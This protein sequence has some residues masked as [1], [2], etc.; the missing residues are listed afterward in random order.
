M[1]MGSGAAM[2]TVAPPRSSTAS[3]LHTARSQRTKLCQA[4]TCQNFVACHIGNTLTND[5]R[6]R[7]RGATTSSSSVTC[8]GV[9]VFRRESTLLGKAT[10]N[11]DWLAGESGRQRMLGGGIDGIGGGGGGSRPIGVINNG[12]NNARSPG[13]MGVRCAAERA[14]KGG[15]FFERIGRVFKEKAKSDIERL[16]SGVSKTRDNLA[17]VDELLT[18]WNLSDSE[19]TLEELED[20]LLVADF[21]PRTS[22]KITD[23]IREE[24]QAGNLKTGAE[25]KQALKQTILDLLTQKEVASTELNLGASHP[26]VIMVVGVNGGGKTTTIGKLA[27]R[28]KNGGAK[29]LM[30]AGDT[31]R[32]AAGEQLEVWAARTGSDIVQAEGPKSRPGSVLSRAV[33]K[34]LDDG[35]VDIVLADTSGRL[36]TNFDLMEEL[37]GCKRAITRAMPSAPHE[38]LLVLDGTTGLNMLP[39]AREFNQVVGVTGFVLTKLDGTARGGCVVSVV[40]ELRIPVKFVGVGEGLDDLQPFDAQTFVDALFPS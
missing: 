38:V 29:I 22:L 3:S 9:S 25:I 7:N 21:G 28:L 34:A 24:V 13:R 30:A 2:M 4:D 37:K 20:A 26:G 33:R 32:A 18:Y 40:D 31:F 15:G 39:Q 12:K 35:D 19:S 11:N 36:H 27:H 10:E 16:F 14:T 17:L 1:A 6:D 8:T 5:S 23:K